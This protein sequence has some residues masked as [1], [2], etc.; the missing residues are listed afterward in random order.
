MLLL[1]FHWQIIVAA[2]HQQSMQEETQTW[3]DYIG[4][5][6]TR[7]RQAMQRGLNYLPTCK[8]LW[9][10][11][12]KLPIISSW[13][14]GLNLLKSVHA[15][16]HFEI[17]WRTGDICICFRLLHFNRCDTMEP[18]RGGDRLFILCFCQIPAGISGGLY[19]HGVPPPATA[20]A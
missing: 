19:G 1:E 16:T 9:Q 3:G 14:V 2:I 20:S 10:A 6:F 4:G 15:E 8:N 13:K 12:F 18:G 7:G 11:E 17:P 5:F